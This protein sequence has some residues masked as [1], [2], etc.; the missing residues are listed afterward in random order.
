MSSREYSP[1]IEARKFFTWL[2]L[3]GMMPKDSKPGQG[4]SSMP[5]LPQEYT[6]EE[7]DQGKKAEKH[8][9]DAGFPEQQQQQQQQQAPKKPPTGRE[10]PAP[11]GGD[12]VGTQMSPRQMTMDEANALLS[13]G[14]K[15]ANPFSSTQLPDTSGS[16][17]FGKAD[18]PQYRSDVPADMYDVPLSRNLTDGSPFVTGD[19]TYEVPTKTNIE[20]LQQ[21]G[22]PIIPVSGQVKTTES[23]DTPIDPKNSGINWGARTAADNSD[24]KLAR[25]R[26]FLDAPGSMQ[27]LRRVESLYGMSYAG[28]QHN[29]A[30][31]NAGK[32]GQDDFIKVSKEDRD[33]Y[34]G[35]RQ[36]A[37]QMREKYMTKVADSQQNDGDAFTSPPNYSM[38]PEVD[39]KTAQTQRPEIEVDTSVLG[40]DVTYQAPTVMF[41]KGRDQYK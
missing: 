18:T 26:A 17:Y 34:M 8:R 27:G 10:T 35:G 14:Y 31:P 37:E 29:M 23:K 5:N 11:N 32:E 2:G 28:G 6:Q 16:P 24:E 41:K 25:R 15:V 3:G 33:A 21:A 9:G 7:L 40:S 12:G 39:L 38:T 13:G 4:R 1:N 22:S 19:Y 36:T 20:Y 30:N